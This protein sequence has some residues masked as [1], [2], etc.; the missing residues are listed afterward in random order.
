MKSRFSFMSFPVLLILLPALVSP[1][2]AKVTILVNPGGFNNIE[3]AAVSEN[4]VNFWD[5]DLTD[6]R[7]CT[8]CFAALELAKFLG[9]CGDFDTVEVKSADELP[10]DGDIFILGSR[11]SNLLL[12]SFNLAEAVKLETDESFNIRT[13]KDNGRLITIIEGRDRVG[14]LY[15][16]YEY[17]DRLGIHFIGLGEKGTVYPAGKV[18]LIEN[19]NITQNPSFVSR[20]Y[21]A[22]EDRRASEGFFV[23][24]ARNK[25]NFWTAAEQ[26]VHLLKKLGMKLAWGDHDMQVFHI[27]PNAVYTY[28]H[29]KFEA[30]NDKPDDPYKIDDLYKGD[31]DGD[32][33][34]SFFEAHPQWY[35][36]YEGERHKLGPLC[37]GYNFCTSNDDASSEFFKNIIRS[38]I[39]GKY[40]Y[41]DVLKFHMID[42]PKWCQCENCQAQ[43]IYTDRL[44]N[45]CGRFMKAI[46][47]ARQAGRLKRD[48]LII[49]SAY[50]ETLAPPTKPLADDFD[51]DNFT[52][53]M[54]PIERCY[55][56]SFADP[57][58]SEIN[59]KLLESYQG[60][61][62][63]KNRNYKGNLMIGEYYNVSLLK[64][65]PT[66][67]P[68]II[69]TDLPWF[70]KAGTK[71]FIY[72]HV[73]TDLWGTW[74][75]NQHMIAKFMW[76]INTNPDKLLNDYYRLYYP[77]TKG[78]TRKFYE[79]LEDA[80]R[81]IKVFKHFVRLYD[82]SNYTLNKWIAVKGLQKEQNRLLDKNAEIFDLEH[83]KYDPYHP[84]INDGPDVVEIM[85]S[86][87]L[88]RKYLDDS[89]IKCTD[90]TEQQRLLEDEKRF[91]YGELMFNFYYHIIRTA[92]FHHRSDK[93]MAEHEF[94]ILKRYAEQLKEVVDI[95]QVSSEDAGDEDGFKATKLTEVYEEF[96]KM[97]GE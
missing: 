54:Y 39:D 12:S 26:P 94:I 92:M 8:E 72:M 47:K 64:S 10:S 11:N 42:L 63:G 27:D 58:C 15:G 59:R 23:W 69:S 13:V 67:Y 81:S 62:V 83:F 17:L 70:Y 48:V 36:L 73:L 60:W 87:R 77:T 3:K 45:L 7:A 5:D 88:A 75:L 1:G 51:Y 90:K 93:T 31:V 30:D 46:K 78:T 61:T 86:M 9:K 6:D 34:L 41:V 95:L 4:K 84:V 74:T 57:A 18:K 16:V 20:G 76:N 29:P 89:L 40:K 14:V 24:M 53:S 2:F 25:V 91:H 21:H 52:M 35:C 68:H 43:G 50:T 38:L 79:H 33:K 56:H 85:E 22:W 37:L 32:G 80:T 71:H 55:A 44:L 49:S 28:N 65:L 82:R 66:L 96:E 19:L 97:Y